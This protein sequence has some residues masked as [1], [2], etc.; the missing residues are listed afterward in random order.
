MFK[1]II[2]FS[3]F[4]L[5]LF[6]M[7]GREPLFSYPVYPSFYS[8][9]ISDGLSQND[10]TAIVQDQ[11]GFM[12]L[13]TRNG[14]NRFDGYTF[15]QYK[16]NLAAKNSL[17][18]N[19]ITALAADPDGQIWVGTLQGLDKFDPKTG[20]CTKY[21]Y[22]SDDGNFRGNFA[23]ISKIYVHADSSVWVLAGGYV[24]CLERSENIFTAY[25]Y[26]SSD[27]IRFTGLIPRNEYEFWVCSE[28]GLFSFS[29]PEK[30]FRLL[31]PG[32]QVETEEG[33]ILKDLRIYAIL[34]EDGDEKLLMGTNHG[35]LRYDNYTKKIKKIKFHG[36]ELG[37]IETLLRTSDGQVWVGA[38]R[39]G[40]FSLQGDSLRPFRHNLANVSSISSD[41][42]L[43]MF[44]DNSGVLWI[45][46]L[47]GGVNRLDLNTEQIQVIRPEISYDESPQVSSVLLDGDSTI[48]M[49][50]GGGRLDKVDKYSGK[51]QTYRINFPSRNYEYDLEDIMSIDKD[52]DDF[53]YLSTGKGLYKF[54]KKKEKF[55]L[56]DILHK[57]QNSVYL[58]LVNDVEKD[59]DGNLW[60]CTPSG[61]FILRDDKTVRLIDR[62]TGS[63]PLP[64]NNIQ[65]IYRDRNDVM[66]VATRGGGLSK[67]TGTIENPSFVNYRGSD[68]PD[69]LSHN[70]ICS[71][72]EDSK[73]RLWLGTW[74]GGIDLMDREKGTFK[75]I[76]VND[77]LLDNT[78][79]GIVESSD[80]LIWAYTY[81]GF[82]S[83][84]IEK[85][86]Y[87]RFRFQL[88]RSGGSEA[89]YGK[90]E[91]DKDDKI[92]ICRLDG[93]AQFDTKLSS[94]EEQSNSVSIIGIDVY[95][96]EKNISDDGEYRMSHKENQFLIKF[97]AFDYS[98]SLGIYSYKMDGVDK[99]WINSYSN[100]ASYS[101]MSPGRYTFHV[102]Y[103]DGR[104]NIASEANSV[105]IRVK[106]PFFASFYAYVLYALMLMA[107]IIL[108]LRYY[109]SKSREK[110]RRVEEQ[111][112]IKNE[113]ALYDA[114]MTFFTNISHEIRTP[115]TL[116]LGPISKLKSY[117]SGSQ[118]LAQTLDMMEN[119]GNRLLTM[120]NQ[121]LDFRKIEAGRMSVNYKDTNLTALLERTVGLFSDAAERKGVRI[122]TNLKEII[123]VSTDQDKIEKII[124]NLMSNAVK[125]SRS[126]IEVVLIAESDTINISVAD[127]GK[128]IPES[129]I[130]KVFNRFYQADN[131][132]G[133]S[134]IGLNLSMELAKLL[135]GDI[136]VSS[137]ENMGT[138]FTLTMP[139]KNLHVE[140][141]TGKSQEIQEGDDSKPLIMVVDD[142]ADM[143]FYIA[144]SLGQDYRILEASDG[145]TAEILLKSVSPDLI[146]SDIMMPGIDGI[147]LTKFIRE[148]KRMNNVPIIIASAR[149][150]EED[151]ITC[152]EAGADA[153][154]T[155]P[156]SAEFLKLQVDKIISI[157]KQAKEQ[158]RIELLASQEK[159]NIQSPY[160]KTLKKIVA[161]M[162]ENIADPD[163]NVETLS[164]K[165]E[166]GRMSI[167]R[168]MKS[169]I[170][171][172][173]SEFIR[174][175]RLSRACV[176]LEEGK[177][178]VN[179]ISYMVGFND[180]KYFSSCF[181]K[182]YRVSP[183]EYGKAH[184]KS[185]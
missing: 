70:N 125:F 91:I 90:M 158:L 54:D 39:E 20:N 121:L 141:I 99:K 160:E 155:K 168:I 4:L 145:Q 157:Q 95:G 5:S 3:A 29:V 30:K 92:Y 24:C 134:G 21:G 8:L 2:F 128:V 137:E 69:S 10:V 182:R 133:G 100:E 63:S 169:T 101:N 105:K 61:I 28:R 56:I 80:G 153:Y 135:G 32:S 9:N 47:R 50:L 89:E 170:G 97:S 64:K 123:T 36:E 93:L 113:K 178:N 66:W 58:N 83:I 84:N 167:Y 22:M 120:V 156:F 15:V 185:N 96:K 79:F 75:R 37:R 55:K 163:F 77:G 161:L 159:T 94:G 122:M 119:N 51:I 165:M 52:G 59:K 106:P 27:R 117:C 23:E 44:E 164:E 82:T 112:K 11:A 149:T 76:T 136:S 45:G 104:G 162:K 142:N 181:K 124:Y 48:W 130:D 17:S 111:I 57:G 25:Y 67:F 108:A 118:E 35:L 49:G 78:V 41:N 33:E 42:I 98:S 171:Q 177:L 173:P 81:Q 109:A 174:D 71:I 85:G 146:V 68:N 126:K 144:S 107:S 116:V 152:L 38:Q 127:D 151:R 132:S 60:C 147:D 31:I 40:L 139:A 46:T 175:F 74:G 72:F 154:I 73:G 110:Q 14:L 172:T 16:Q 183:S 140:D 129:E 12:W 1:K 131:S 115:L 34:A 88:Q 179:E 86:K 103:T 148:N 26:P 65:T 184:P 166:L 176:L 150:S 114:K 7:G 138:V 18:S 180:P 53:L 143:R 13:G 62:N 87:R 6:I 43:S 102:R 19:I